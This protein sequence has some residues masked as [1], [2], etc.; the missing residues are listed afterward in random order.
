MENDKRSVSAENLLDIARSLSL[1]FDDL[2]TGTAAP[3]VRTLAAQLGVRLGAPVDGILA[4]Y[5]PIESTD[6]NV[7]P[8][9]QSHTHPSR[10]PRVTRDTDSTTQ[11]PFNPRL[12]PPAGR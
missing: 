8:S 9:H 12:S 4:L 1:P 2:M 11:R 3:E 7:P 6:R 5:D 10:R